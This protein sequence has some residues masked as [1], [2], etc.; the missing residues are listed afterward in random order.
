M[1]PITTDSDRQLPNDVRF[2][3]VTGHRRSG[4]TWVCRMLNSHP[5]ICMRNEGRFLRDESY[6]I[7]HWL[8]EDRVSRWAQTPV[9]RG[10]WM[11]NIEPSELKILLMRGMMES[12]MREA[13]RRAPYTSQSKLKVIGEK[14]TVY[15]LTKIE[16]F[17]A[18]FPDAAGVIHIVRDGRDA[19][20]SDLFQH[21]ALG[22]WTMLPDQEH[23]R[24][25]RR[26]HL[27][28]QGDEVA[29]FSEPVLRCLANQWALSMRG[30]DRAGALF[31]DR[32]IELRYERLLEEPGEIARVFEL[33]GVCQDNP[34]VERCIEQNTFEAHSGGR[35][36]GESDPE[37]HA[38][39][40]IAGDWRT[41][42]R[43]EDERVFAEVVGQG[44]AV[45]GSA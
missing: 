1:T 5:E 18:L 43:Q 8:D 35:I 10:G 24:R 23:L 15:L 45:E 12:V 17:H 19:M 14:T 11:L 30:A 36:A 28:G 13:A 33:L 9:A 16:L 40:G 29:L 7:E 37:H 44:A 42:F 32:F 3:F 39:K 31:G 25:S 6:S 2:A 34:V 26:F 22:T 4:T 38:R 27:E 41:Y 21:F 20:V